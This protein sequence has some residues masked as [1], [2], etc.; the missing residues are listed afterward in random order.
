MYV[1]VITDVLANEK[2]A[3]VNLIK[4]LFHLNSSFESMAL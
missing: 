4:V 2:V 3:I 1:I